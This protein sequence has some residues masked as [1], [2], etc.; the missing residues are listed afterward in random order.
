[1]AWEKF[2]RAIFTKLQN[3]KSG[4]LL[5]EFDK[6]SAL[7]YT[8]IGNSKVADALL[9]KVGYKYLFNGKEIIKRSHGR[10]GY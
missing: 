2:R 8:N 10:A 3:T 7:I 4:Q 5:I 6:P 1:M 9:I